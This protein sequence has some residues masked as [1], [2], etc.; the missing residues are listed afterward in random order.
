MT[1]RRC[2]PRCGLSVRTR[3]FRRETA[4][5]SLKQSWTIYL[6]N[7][8]Y[9]VSDT[10]SQGWPAQG[11]RVVNNDWRN[12]ERFA[13]D[14][15]DDPRVRYEDNWNIRMVGQN[16]DRT[17]IRLKDE[18]P[19]FGKGADKA[20]VQFY[21]LRCGSMTNQGNYFENITI[22]TG[23][24]NPGAVGLKWN[25]S[26]W[27]GVRNVRVRSGDGQGRA[28]LMMDTANATGYLRD[29]DIEGFDVGIELGAGS[30]SM[31]VL[32]HVTLS[33]QRLA[34]IQVPVGRARFGPR[35]ISA[36]KVLVRDAPVACKVGIS[37]HLV[38]LDS[39]LRS[40]L[41]QPACIEI[42]KHG[43][44]FARDVEVSGYEVAV[45]RQGEAVLK[46][47]SIAEYVSD[48]P[49][50]LRADVPATSMRL[51]VKDAPVCL[52]EPDSSQW[53]SVDELRRPWRRH[54]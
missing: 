38:L 17:I 33:G 46:G 18:S 50:S 47:G 1:P 30:Q 4:T 16:R 35:P 37:G 43:H 12:V 27:G 14:S 13:V 8:V 15:P 22:D 10:V 23:R 7:G 32:E 54:P 51:P 44:L 39:E 24:G 31:V 6:P 20:V 45:V 29:L 49:V 11:Y 5:L 42:E 52:P 36:R 19:G 41:Q 53:A 21:L 3:T 9:L 34:A 2:A 26:N 40:S 28:G 25:G 48:E